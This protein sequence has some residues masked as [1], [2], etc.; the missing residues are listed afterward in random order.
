MFN[1]PLIRVRG[2]PSTPPPCSITQITS[3]DILYAGGASP[4]AGPAGLALPNVAFQASYCSRSDWA[5][6]AAVTAKAASK[7]LSEI[8]GICDSSIAPPAANN[9]LPTSRMGPMAAS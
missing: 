6:V 8:G 3:G 7:C 5:T 9:L 4:Y 1:W 2:T